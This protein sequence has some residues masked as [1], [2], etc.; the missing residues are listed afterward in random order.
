MLGDRAFAVIGIFLAG[1]EDGL[2]VDEE[3]VASVIFGEVEGLVGLGEELIR[4]GFDRGDE[5]SNTRTNGKVGA[6]TGMGMGDF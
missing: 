6:N 1:G 2:V 3:L 4:R 5:A